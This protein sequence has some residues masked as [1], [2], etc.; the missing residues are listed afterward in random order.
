[1]ICSTLMRALILLTSLGATGCRC[2]TSSSSRRHGS[3]RAIRARPPEKL[4]ASQRCDRGGPRPRHVTS[5]RQLGIASHHAGRRGYRVLELGTAHSHPSEW[6]ATFSRSS[7]K[8]L[9]YG[10]IIEIV[11]P[12]MGRAASWGD[13]L[14]DGAGA[15]VG[16]FFASRIGKRRRARADFAKPNNR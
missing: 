3:N 12:F 11:Q 14:A 10:G 1:M 8:A 6:P 2:S 4:L 7:G 5:R 15:F 16:A 9:A 13:L